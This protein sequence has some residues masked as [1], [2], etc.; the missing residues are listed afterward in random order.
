LA[1]SSGARRAIPGHRRGLEGLYESIVLTGPY[2]YLALSVIVLFGAGW[3]PRV[4][5]W[6]AVALLFPLVFLTGMRQSRQVLVSALA[7]FSLLRRDGP[8]WPIRLIQFQLAMIYGINAIAKTTPGYLSGEALMGMSQS[9]P[10]FLVDL[11][12]GYVPMGF[13]RIPVRVAAVLSVATEYGLALGFWFRRTR[14][15]TAAVGV[16]FHL[17]LKTIVRIH[18]LDWTSMFLYLAFLLP[19]PARPRRFKR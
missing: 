6:C 17:V 19:F 16:A 2:W 15:A 14:L 4:L 12:S 11:S 10:N 8:M 7:V 13:L 1:P 3:R 18:M 9:L 5:G